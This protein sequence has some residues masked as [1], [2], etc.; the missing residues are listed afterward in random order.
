MKKTGEMEYTCEIYAPLESPAYGGTKRYYHPLYNEKELEKDETG[1]IIETKVYMKKDF[2]YETADG[3]TVDGKWDV[4]LPTLFIN[5]AYELIDK[6]NADDIFKLY[7]Q[8]IGNKSYRMKN[9]MSIIGA[10]LK[11]YNG[12]DSYSAVFN[13]LENQ[14]GYGYMGGVGC[15]KNIHH[16]TFDKII[17]V[18]ENLFKNEKELAEF[19]LAGM[20]DVLREIREGKKYLRDVIAEK[21]LFVSLNAKPD[22]QVS[23]AHVDAHGFPIKGATVKDITCKKCLKKGI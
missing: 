9:T 20:M 4:N 10:L 19:W 17:G 18:K 13:I 16:L 1:N 3:E 5:N 8:Y 15:G 22:C 12:S 11:I 23:V 7:K 14:K 6:D 2:T 21:D